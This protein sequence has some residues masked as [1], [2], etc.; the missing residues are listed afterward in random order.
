MGKCSHVICVLNFTTASGRFGRSV[1]VV[2]SK[3]R[4]SLNENTFECLDGQKYYKVKSDKSK[5]KLYFQCYKHRKGCRV[6]VHTIYTDKDEDWLQVIYRNESHNHPL[7]RV[8]SRHISRMCN[9][10]KAKKN[11]LRSTLQ[12]DFHPLKYVVYLYV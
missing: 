9:P 12:N 5:P 10:I 7:P 2:D 8:S 4:G 11:I 3:M 6:M 1:T